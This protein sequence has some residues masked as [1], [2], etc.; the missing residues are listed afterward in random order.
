MISE[1][2][3]SEMNICRILIVFENYAVKKLQS[4]LCG[5][6]PI[7]YGERYIRSRPIAMSGVLN[8]RTR[9]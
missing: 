3:A 5:T 2:P 1:S 4:G 9:W 7:D 8:L 6:F